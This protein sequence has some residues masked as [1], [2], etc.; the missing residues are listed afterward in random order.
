MLFAYFIRVIRVNILGGKGSEEFSNHLR[1]TIRDD[2]GGGDPYTHARTH[3]YTH[4]HTH[5]RTHTRTHVH[6]Y[7]HT[8]THTH[9]RA[10]A[11]THA[12]G[13]S[14]QEK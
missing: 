5:A 1:Q 4:T 11:H 13:Q 10:H 6:A 14:S 3:A 9:T 2:M 12:Q 7:T 8:H